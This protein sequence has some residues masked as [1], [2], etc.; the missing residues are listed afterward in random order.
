ML[1]IF[2]EVIGYTR[3][4]LFIENGKSVKA[5]AIPKKHCAVTYFFLMKKTNLM[6]SGRTYSG[7][8]LYFIIENLTILKLTQLEG[9][10][11]RWIL[12]SLSSYF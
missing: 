2:F 11:I 8:P 5:D 7:K 10:C 1:S 4:D 3:L 6:E 9:R 12:H